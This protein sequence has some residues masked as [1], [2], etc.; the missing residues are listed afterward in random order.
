MKS[1]EGNL[2]FNITRKNS[3]VFWGSCGLIT[4]ILLVSLSLGDYYTP[5]ILITV[6][7]NHAITSIKQSPVFKDHLLVLQWKISYKLN[8]F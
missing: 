2:L 4:I 1:V 3:I 5:V 8:F 6:K 7:P